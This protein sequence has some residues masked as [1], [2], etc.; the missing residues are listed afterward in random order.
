[1]RRLA[2]LLLQMI[3]VLTLVGVG[4]LETSARQ[5]EGTGV[6]DLASQCSEGAWASL[7]RSNSPTTPFASQEDCSTYLTQS[8][9]AVTLQVVPPTAIPPTAIP[10][11]AIPPTVTPTDSGIAAPTA[12]VATEAGEI[13]PPLDPTPTPVP[14]PTSPPLNT[15]SLISISGPGPFPLEQAA[16]QTLSYTYLVTTLRTATSLHAEL[17]HADGSLA[18]AWWLQGQAGDS[19]WSSNGGVIDVAEY[20][21]RTPGAS[22]TVTF[23]V[24][25]PAE[26]TEPESVSLYVRGTASSE[27]GDQE[28][29]V[30]GQA[31]VALFSGVAPI[32]TETAFDQTGA[33]SPDAGGTFNCEQ[34][35]P[36]GT[37]AIDVGEFA[38]FSCT[39]ASGPVR[40]RVNTLSS[41]WEY[42]IDGGPWTSAVGQ[43]SVS[44]WS[45]GGGKQV[46]YEIDLRFTGDLLQLPP[47]AQGQVEVEII[48]PADTS[49]SPVPVLATLATTRFALVT[50]PVD[51]LQLT[52]TPDALTA[53]VGGVPIA[54]VCAVGGRET[55]GES[56]ATLNQVL[57]TAPSGWTVGG[58]GAT[59]GSTLT[60]TP[61]ASIGAGGT[62]TFSFS[63][64][65]VSC[66]TDAGTVAIS[67]TVTFVGSGPIPGSAASLSAEISGEVTRTITASGT[68]LDFGSSTWNGT[69]YSTVTGSLALTFSGTNG[70]QCSSAAGNWSIQISTDGLSGEDTHEQ[71]PASAI[72]YLGTQSS[73][74]VPNG[75]TAAGTD[76]PLAPGVSTTIASG[77]ASFG[78]GV[79]NPMFQLD[80]PSTAPPGAYSGTIRIEVIN[81]P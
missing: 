32:S 13:T 42:R 60:L 38:R 31:A 71:I 41:Y 47:G 10:P 9:L 77:D 25:A 14:S 61:N 35:A 54:V 46:T 53:E 26:V 7:A 50:P 29:G 24:T 36:N 75:L 55:L 1:M 73:V 5:D 4:L 65:P 79:W 58:D 68:P 23:I 67:S 16:T 6:D 27:S 11:T 30:G 51:G 15:D 80:P 19:S 59:S 22:F 63:L 81:A 39:Y 69:D 66:E 17:R 8:G 56:V 62:H 44:A 34:T 20:A 37:A 3:L 48:N 43:D 78:G 57:I 76:I 45:S 2:N 33:K 64:T 49:F 52:C 28:T 18:T 72:T 12:T 40:L 74:N 21:T 70:G